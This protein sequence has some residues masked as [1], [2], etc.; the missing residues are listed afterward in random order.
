MNVSNKT[1]PARKEAK[2]IKRDVKEAVGHEIKR[3]SKAKGNGVK[4]RSAGAKNL[5]L[6][7]L[8]RPEV[9][10]GIGVPDSVQTGSVKFVTVHRNGFTTAPIAAATWAAWVLSPT[11]GYDWT[12]PGGSPTGTSLHSL[13]TSAAQTAAGNSLAQITMNASVSAADSAMIRANFSAYRIVSA[14]CN[15][16]CTGAALNNTG[17]HSMNCVSSRCLPWNLDNTTSA[18]GNVGLGYATGYGT[19]ATPFGPYAAT[20]GQ[21]LDSGGP[22]VSVN[23]PLRCVWCPQDSTSTNYINV[24]PE[25][26]AVDVQ[27][28]SIARPYQ[29]EGVGGEECIYTVVQKQWSEAYDLD[30]ETLYI[31]EQLGNDRPMFIYAAAGCV[32]NQTFMIETVVNWEAI[33]AISIGSQFGVTPSPSNPE[34]LAQATNVMAMVPPASAPTMIGDMNT[35]AQK[36]ALKVVPHLYDGTDRKAAVEGKSSGFNFG[37]LVD[38]LVNSALTLMESFL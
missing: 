11:I 7:T 17:Q 3:K 18:A 22:V 4:A 37:A 33:P 6:E 35:L 38:P 12:S 29:W 32:N 34:E 26:A 23:N 14:S 15:V 20:I 25:T 27:D 16:T 1:K 10:H 13:Q 36:A 21:L 2:Q 24:A 8:L 30:D 9:I 28:N 31:Q 19:G 5:Y